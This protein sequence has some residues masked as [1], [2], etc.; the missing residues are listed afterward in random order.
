MNTMCCILLVWHISFTGISKPI[1]GSKHALIINFY[2]KNFSTIFIAQQTN[3]FSVGQPPPP[4][5][6]ISNASVKQYSHPI[7][8]TLVSY[9]VNHTITGTLTL[10]TPYKDIL[11]NIQNS[12]RLL[13]YF[14]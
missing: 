11:A 9:W 13:I 3:L 12:S 5:K 1:Q 6:N 4:I 14:L 10:K 7:S 8:N 2:K